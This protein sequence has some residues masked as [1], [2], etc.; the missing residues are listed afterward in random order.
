M[1]PEGNPKKDVKNANHER[2]FKNNS[3]DTSAKINSLNS[4]KNSAKGNQNQLL[5]YIK[6]SKSNKNNVSSDY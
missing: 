4:Y 3:I 6:S 2:R 5:E 1:M